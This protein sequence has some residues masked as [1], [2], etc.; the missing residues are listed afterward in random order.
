MKRE[1]NDSKESAADKVIKTMSEMK[2]AT[3][4][5]ES[6]FISP[7]TARFNRLIESRLWQSLG[8]QRIQGACVKIG[9]CSAT[10]AQIAKNLI[11]AGVRSVFIYDD[12][13]V[14]QPDLGHHFFL[15]QESV[16]RNRA[17]A[18]CEL[19][20]E[21]SPSKSPTS[22]FDDTLE[23]Y[24]EDCD[25]LDGFWKWNAYM[26]VRRP[27]SADELVSGFCWNFYVPMFLVQTCGLVA[28]IRLQ[29]RELSDSLVN[30]RLDCPFPSLSAFAKSFEMDTLER[31]EHAHIPAVVIVI[32]FL[33]LFKSK[34][35]APNFGV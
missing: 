3:A 22:W 15:N 17:E 20:D 32:Q 19:L 7:N 5:Q 11:L 27:E 9:D 2:G 29:I 34:G 1:A 30:L 23:S 24:I 35:T 10:S 14:C 12:K 28:T 18:C 33:E 4:D 13:L 31:H 16:G 6:A 8:Q 26:C 21:L 25:D